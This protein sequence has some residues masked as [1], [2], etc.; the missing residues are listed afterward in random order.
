MLTGKTWLGT[1]LLAIYILLAV[2][3]IA[4]SAARGDESDRSVTADE[5]GYK[6]KTKVELRRQLS[7]IQYLVT[8]EE[9]TE[10]AFRNAYWDNKKEGTYVCVVCDKPLFS[11]ETKFE[12]GTGWP[13][14]WQPL[15]KDAVGTKTDWKM[16]YPRTEV[17]CSRCRAHLGHVFNDGPPPTGLRYCMNSAS[18]NFKDAKEADEKEA[19][20]KEA[21]ADAPADVDK[22]AQ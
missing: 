6:P 13:S 11:S 18:L 12:S 10:P 21:S 16:V 7:R 1:V 17:H 5:D 15:D 3:A 4:S 8:Q 22:G 2:G 14:F 19:V 20:E 9:G